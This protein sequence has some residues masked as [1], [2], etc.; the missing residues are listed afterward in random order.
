MLLAPVVLF[1]KAGLLPIAVLLLAVVRL[2]SAEKPIA[3]L[4]TPVVLV[5][6]AFMPSAVL[7]PPV[8]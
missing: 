6:R 3:V 5:K 2:Y 1:R 4:L 8:R 7:L